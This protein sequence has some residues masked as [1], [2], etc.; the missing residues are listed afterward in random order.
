[1]QEKKYTIIIL[2]IKNYFTYYLLT[3]QENSQNT[4]RVKVYYKE[5]KMIYFKNVR[6]EGIVSY[7]D[8]IS[9]STDEIMETKKWKI[10]IWVKYESEF[11]TL[12]DFD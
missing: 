9:V 8:V 4:I 11:K 10:Q 7:D 12:M 1:M 5:K 6:S 2:Q 3:D